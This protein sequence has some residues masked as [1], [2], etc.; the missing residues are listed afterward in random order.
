[1]FVLN[2]D[3]LDLHQSALGQILHS[4]G[5]TGRLVLCEVL[6]VNSVHGSEISDVS[7]QNGGLDHIV[8]GVTGLS[9]NVLHI[10]QGL[11]GLSSDIVACELAGSGVNGDLTGDKDDVTGL[12]SLRIGADGSGSLGG[13]NGIVHKK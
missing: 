8:Q 12:N 7:Q 2:R 3:G 6:C 13:M 4:E 10:G 9:Q 11:V 5:S 1:M